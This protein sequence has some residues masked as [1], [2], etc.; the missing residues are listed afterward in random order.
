MKI[1]ILFSL[2]VFF[3]IES[4]AQRTRTQAR[5]SPAA[6]AKPREVGQSAI[7]FDE[8]LSLLRTRPSLFADSVQRL[9]RGRK[10]QI[11]G[12]A[13]ADGV[14]FFR[15]TVSQGRTGWI[16]SDAVIG[17]FRPE[18]EERFAKLVLASS[19]FPQVE[20]AVNFLNEYPASQF[21]PP[22]LLLFGDILEVSALRLTR[23]ANNRLNRREMAASAAP[24]HS[25]YLNFVSLDRYR[26][27]GIVFV[28]N[29][30][31][32]SFHYNGASWLEI[33]KKYPGSNEALEAQSRLDL[34]KEKMERSAAAGS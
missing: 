24:M 21:R 33:T 4:S 1:L 5:P 9:R 20:L 30:S 17:K 7:V 13:E 14:K 26:R 31:T 27:L 12:V 6:A 32:R 25:Y 18:D 23:D 2:V 16:Q 34:L 15:V 22:V 8:S 3:C 29:P 11:T 19:G 28:F 10:L